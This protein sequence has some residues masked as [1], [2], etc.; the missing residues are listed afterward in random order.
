M[1]PETSS[2][3]PGRYTGSASSFLDAQK[4]RKSTATLTGIVATLILGLLYV[5][6]NGNIILP[7]IPILMVALVVVLWRN[8][9]ALLPIT[10]SSACLFELQ[11]YN[12]SDSLTDRVPMFWDINSGFQVYA[13]ANFHGLPVSPFELILLL[14][15]I[16]GTVKAVFTHRVGMRGGAL[17]APIL[18]YLA[19]VL[20]G[21]LHGLGSGGE[22]TKA[23]F[24]VR[25]QA[26]VF[27][28]YLIALNCGQDAQDATRSALWSTV[29]CIGIKGLLLS[30]RYLITLGG[31][32]IAEQGVGAHEESFFFDMF[33]ML[34]LVLKMG[35]VEPRMRTVML[36]LL[37]FVLL[38]NLANMRRTATGALAL[39]VPTL[40]FLSYVGFAN[41]RKFIVQLAVGIVAVAAVYLPAFWNSDGAIGQPARAIRSQFDPSARDQSSDLYR[42]EEDA[43][44][45]ATMRTEPVFGYGYGKPIIQVAVMEDLTDIDPLILYLTH[46]QILWIWMRL[47]TIGFIVFWIMIANWLIRASQAAADSELTPLARSLGVFV[48]VIVVSQLMFGLYDMQLANMRNMLFTGTFL[49]VLAALLRQRDNELLLKRAERLRNAVH[50]HLHAKMALDGIRD[51]PFRASVLLESDPAADNSSTGQRLLTGASPQPSSV[52]AKARL[53]RQTPDFKNRPAPVWP[54]YLEL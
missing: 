8:P 22:F 25:A 44:L 6:G 47:G 23:L 43:N 52:S 46:D 39:A 31:H 19:C 4:R 26:Y 34:Y 42:V 40:L 37:P 9:G 21:V 35:N 27:I 24:E 14:G 1:T 7:L 54:D 45:M 12:F 51:E 3:I 18:A 36:C 13:H 15:C 38:A 48:A 11:Q 16:F 28:A 17:L 33:V 2:T 30:F 41:R 53:P 49:G 29:I 32:T 20:F 10:V 50:G 5:V